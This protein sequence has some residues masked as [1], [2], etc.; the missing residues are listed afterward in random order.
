MEL[1]LGDE[2]YGTFAK[3]FLTAVAGENEIEVAFGDTGD[4]PNTSGFLKV[5]AKR[6]VTDARAWKFNIGVP[7]ARS[8]DTSANTD[9]Q[10]EFEW[11]AHRTFRLRGQDGPVNGSFL[12]RKSNGHAV[13]LL[14]PEAWRW[15][16][17]ISG[18]VKISFLGTGQKYGG[19]WKLIV[20]VIGCC[21][22]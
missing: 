10:E 15:D 18:H 21:V 6:V 2:W 4:T 8:T 17:V 16:A 3:P 13:A 14:E 12:I 5:S 11:H 7:N 20:F 22:Q 1:C 19:L 9:V